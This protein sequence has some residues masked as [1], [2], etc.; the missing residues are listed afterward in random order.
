MLTHDVLVVGGGPVG[1]FA[2]ALLADLGLDVR[3][4]ERRSEE[5]SLSRAIG[6]HPP[7][8]E[9]FDRLG[10]AD[11]LV[12]EAVTV[13][14]GV[15]VSGGRTLGTVPFDRVSATH[16]YVAALPQHRTESL[17]REA[18]AVRSPEALVTGVEVGTVTEGPESVV[19]RGVR[20]GEPVEAAARFVVAADGWKSTVRRRLGVRSATRDYPDSFAMG[21]FRDD[22]GHG[23]DAV[24]HLEREGVVESF[25]LPGGLR[26]WVLH[27]D[28]PVHDPSAEGLA[29]E[30]ALRV[31]GV[32]DPSTNSMLSG[33]SVRRRFVETMALGRVLLVGDAAHE[34]SPIGGQGM[35]L[36]WADAVAAAD[37][38]RAAL[39]VAGGR[40]HDPTRFAAFSATR[41]RAARRAAAQAELNMALGRP[42]S[43]PALAAKRA[44]LGLA[45]TLP[46]RR[47][48]ARTYAMSWGR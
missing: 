13:R 1:A 7:S 45:L 8:L 44:G 33:F 17:L 22:S 35:N 16:P 15:A 9:A 20:H 36:G 24:V 19:V 2:G 11:A 42:A 37:E 10:V 5:P 27:V 18:L 32:V 26:R 28:G 23:S 46:T 39:R 21:D 6:V 30:I 3:V 43:G 14:R 47:A 12:A 4:W 41:L 31:G 29:A 40:R 25:P 48:L 38:L 34:I